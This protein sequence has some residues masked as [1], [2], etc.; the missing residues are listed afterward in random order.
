MVHRTQQDMARVQTVDP[1]LG[2][3]Y[4]VCPACRARLALQARPAEADCPRCGFAGTVAW[5]E[6]E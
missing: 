6:I 2:Q 4:A 3:V 1:S 5:W